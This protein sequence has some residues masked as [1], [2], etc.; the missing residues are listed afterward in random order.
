MGLTPHKQFTDMQAASKPQLMSCRRVAVHN[1]PP[2]F[3]AP[4]QAPT[5][6]RLVAAVGQQAAAAAHG[7]EHQQLLWGRRALGG[8]ELLCT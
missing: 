6:Q 3:P 4:P 7:Q 8:R 2:H 5:H 1:V